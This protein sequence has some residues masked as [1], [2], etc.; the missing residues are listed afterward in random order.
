[1]DKLLELL[2]ENSSFT[3]K[4]LAL[5]LGEPEDYIA[6]QIKEYEQN[7]IIKGYQALVNW[8]KVP[9]AMV[10]A[11]IE[12]KVTPKK[13]T[14]FDEIA[15]QIMAFEEVSSMYLMAGSFDLS[16]F[17]NGKT[18]QDVASFVARKLSCIDGV[19]A[20]ATH[21]MLKAYKIGGVSLTD[22]DS[23]SDERGIVL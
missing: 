13:E 8:E 21:F 12:L 11:I 14:G 18:M 17:V 16:V 7:G 22:D 9:D 15:E 20:T 3:N 4:E 23:S 19:I 6:A 2:S 10:T 1:M 5:M